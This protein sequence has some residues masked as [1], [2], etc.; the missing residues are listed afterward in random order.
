MAK[1][2]KTTKKPVRKSPPK[3]RPASAPDANLL[4]DL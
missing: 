4:V 2:K 1:A 3:K